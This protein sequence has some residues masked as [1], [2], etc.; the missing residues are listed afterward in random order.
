MGRVVV[1]V[2]D[3]FHVEGVVKRLK[4]IGKNVVTLK[5]EVAVRSVEQHTES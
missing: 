2:V 4:E 5:S 3:G 1:M